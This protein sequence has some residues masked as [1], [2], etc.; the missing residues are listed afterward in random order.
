[1]FVSKIRK[2]TNLLL[3]AGGN[4]PEHD[5]TPIFFLSNRRGHVAISDRL[6]ARADDDTVS[7]LRAA[8]SRCV[9]TTAEARTSL[10]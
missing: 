9:R 10:S 2:V 6:P 5:A 1:M 8:G 4:E 3:R 7:C